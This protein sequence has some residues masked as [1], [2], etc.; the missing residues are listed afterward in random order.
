[1]VEVD[2]QAEIDRLWDALKEGGSTE[3]CGWLRDRWGLSW[4]I[5][6]KRLGELMMDPDPAVSKRVTEAMLNLADNAV[7]ATEDGG[8]IEVGGRLEGAEIVLWVRD[9]GDGVAP[10]VA[11]SLFDRTPRP[12]PRR[13]GSTGLGLPIVAAIAEAHG[14]RVD[15][16]S[17]P[18]RGSTFTLVLPVDGPGDGAADPEEDVP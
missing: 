15:V 8:V 6:P 1:M 18:G 9:D 16:A 10:E 12:G 7:D 17:E 2:T 3:Q 4:Q 14:G 5:A 11:D 13:P